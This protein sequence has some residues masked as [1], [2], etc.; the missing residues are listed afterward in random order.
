[1]GNTLIQSSRC[2]SGGE[3]FDPEVAVGVGGEHCNRG[4]QRAV[5]VRW[6]PL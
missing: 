5:E 1:M 6:G 2:R 4:L 3:H